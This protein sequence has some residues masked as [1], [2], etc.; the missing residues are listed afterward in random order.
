MQIL[1]SF[2]VFTFKLIEGNPL[3]ALAKPNSVILTSASAKKYFGNVNAVGKVIR[4]NSRDLNS[5][6]WND[7]TV[8][9]IMEDCPSNSQIKFDFLASFCSLK[10]A[11]PGDE[12]WWNADYYT[13]L[14]LKTPGS[15]K[16]L[17]AKIPAYMK[18]QNKELGLTGNDYM[19]FH[20]EPLK[21]VHL[22]SEAQGGFEPPGD[23]KYI[24]IFSLIALLILFNCMCKLCQYY[25]GQGI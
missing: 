24:V 17:H 21:R 12:V 22:Y 4:V 11:K 3:L 15:I 10:S 19:T 5:V 20:L 16:T 14:L 25:H 1:H 6:A 13:Y 2:K 18:T 7:Y 8:S 9:G 23:Y